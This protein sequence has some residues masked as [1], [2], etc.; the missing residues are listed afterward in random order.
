M[1]LID[2]ILELEP[3]KR[4]LGYK[5]VTSNEPFFVGH[6]PGNPLMPGVLMIEA[7]AQLGGS[8]IL[9]PGAISR[10]TPYLAG[11]NKMKFRRPVIPG[12]CLMMETTVVRARLNI[13]WVSAE[14]RVEGKLVCSG[15]LMFSI[16]NAP[17][18][19]GMDASILS[20]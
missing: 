10:K 18:T 1:L 3:G 11:V 9:E 15:E 19:F 4:A 8:S 13:G 6:F 12:D 16:V 17:T 5:N 20:E 14:A 2:R 7:L